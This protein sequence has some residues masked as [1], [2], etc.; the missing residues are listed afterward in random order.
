[1]ECVSWLEFV[2]TL[3][4]G[5]DKSPAADQVRGMRVREPVLV[6]NHLTTRAQQGFESDDNPPQ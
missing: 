5:K 6:R 2:G 1:M 3:P 4:K